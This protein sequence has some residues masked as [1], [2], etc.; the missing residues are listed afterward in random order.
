MSELFLTVF[1]CLRMH[2]ITVGDPELP[3]SRSPG[4]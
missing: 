3:D 1:L 4:L 2:T